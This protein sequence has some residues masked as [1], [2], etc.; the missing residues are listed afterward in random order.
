[1]EHFG[2]DQNWLNL[3]GVRRMIWGIGN[4]WDNVIGILRKK[5]FFLLNVGRFSH[6][7]SLKINPPT[8]SL[9]FLL[10]IMFAS[11]TKHY[12]TTVWGGDRGCMYIYICMYKLSK[13]C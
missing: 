10:L 6:S 13:N 9:P 5:G 11:Y 3:G 4:G 7:G 8:N 1:M 12:K 2:D